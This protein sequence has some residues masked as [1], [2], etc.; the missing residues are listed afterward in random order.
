MAKTETQSRPTSGR[1]SSV[2][3]DGVAWHVGEAWQD[4]V[5]GPG[6]PDWLDLASDPR[7]T[8]LKRQDVREVWRL[9]LD[10][11]G[12]IVKVY[13]ENG[14]TTRVKQMVT[15]WAAQREY[16]ITRKAAE[17]G[18]TS[19]PVGYATS[20]RKSPSDRARR[21]RISVLVL[22]DRSPAESLDLVWKQISTQPPNIRRGETNCLAKSLASFIARAHRLGFLHA[23]CHPRNI[24]VDG[25]NDSQELHTCLSYIDLPGSTVRPNP[26]EGQRIHNLASLTHWFLWHATRADRWRFLTHY[27]AESCAK[28]ESPQSRTW[29]KNRR[30]EMARKIDRAC[31]KHTRKW[32]KKRDRRILRGDGRYFATVELPD[33]WRGRVTVRLHHGTHFP[34]ARR[35]ACPPDEWK[36]RLTTLLQRSLAERGHHELTIERRPVSAMGR[37][38]GW[39]GVQTPHQRAFV[40]AHRLRHRQIPC[41]CPMV[42][43]EH[44]RSGLLRDTALVYEN[45]EYAEQDGIPTPPGD[46]TPTCVPVDEWLRY[47][48]DEG[49]DSDRQRMLRDRERLLNTIASR[50]A[51]PGRMGGHAVWVSGGPDPRCFV[52]GP[53]LTANNPG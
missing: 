38:L 3:R 30:K 26:T 50:G 35:P 24:L 28:E 14:W 5:C 36:Q 7:A 53:S 11:A 4:Y 33:G 20:T 46:R 23:D 34:A 51:V 22:Q 8:L 47:H 48:L 41:L 16:A 37:W 1:N 27:V 45:P 25:A 9:Q 10:G 15:G 6:A 39:L 18:L 52:H 44:R 31:D 40:D 21:R 2:T 42:L 43:L 29:L 13:Q 49:A 12:F 17:L 32:W 19:S